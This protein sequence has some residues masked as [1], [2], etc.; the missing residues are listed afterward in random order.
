MDNSAENYN[1]IL[2]GNLFF[3]LDYWSVLPNGLVPVL[4]Q[5]DVEYEQVMI[6][7]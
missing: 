5:E 3:I 2:N 6:M 7:E 4:F 1:E